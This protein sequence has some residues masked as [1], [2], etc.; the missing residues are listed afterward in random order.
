ILVK[1]VFLFCCPLQLPLTE[2]GPWFFKFPCKAAVEF[3]FATGANPGHLGAGG[4][5]VQLQ[6]VISAGP[7]DR[8]CAEQGAQVGAAGGHDAHPGGKIQAGASV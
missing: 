8:R 4:T 7:G 3:L 6:C 2:I 1:A 5:S